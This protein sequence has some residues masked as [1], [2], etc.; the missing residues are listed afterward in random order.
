LLFSVSLDPGVGPDE[1]SGGAVL[2]LPALI[3]LGYGCVAVEADFNFV[4]MVGSEFGRVGAVILDGVRLG[5]VAAVYIHSNE[6][7]REDAF[8]NARV[9]GDDGLGPVRFGLSY[10][11]SVGRVVIARLDMRQGRGEQKKRYDREASRSHSSSFLEASG[12]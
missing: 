7:I 8:E 3:A 2:L 5:I 9:I 6:V 4:E 10:V 12:I 11:G 1:L